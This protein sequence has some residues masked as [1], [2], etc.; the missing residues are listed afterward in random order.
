MA[1]G[2]DGLVLYS[3]DGENWQLATTPTSKPLHIIIFHRDRFIAA[4][5]GGI[6]IT[7][8]DSRYWQLAKTHTKRDIHSIIAS[9]T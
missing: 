7:S 9:P 2:A 3:E 6:I 8:K 5:F 4:G 1:T